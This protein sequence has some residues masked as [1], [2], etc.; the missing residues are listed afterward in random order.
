MCCQF[1]QA[2][3]INQAIT[4]TTLII[5][6]YIP[7]QQSQLLLASVSEKHKTV[8]QMFAEMTQAYA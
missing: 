7:H 1:P 2:K 4:K 8:I 3:I 6:Y 5:P